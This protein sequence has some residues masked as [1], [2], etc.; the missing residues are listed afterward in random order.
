MELFSKDNMTEVESYITAKAAYLKRPIGGTIELLPLCNMTCKMCY[1]QKS[2]AEMRKEGRMLTCDEWISIAG[3]A[4]EAGVLSILITGGEPLLFPEFERLYK[5]LT[6]MGFIIC[7]NTNGTL[8]NEHWADLFAEYPCRRINMTIY[9]KDNQTYADLCGNPHGFDQ[10][11]NTVALLKERQVP[12]RFN[13]TPS[14]WNF[15]QV[16]EIADIARALDV[17][18]SCGTYIFPNEEERLG[19]ETRPT[20]E[21]YAD[22]YL[23]TA[24]EHHPTYPMEIIAKSRLFSLKK[25][26]KTKANDYHCSA[27]YNGFWIDW[28]GYLST[29]GIYRLSPVNLLEHSFT[30]AWEMAAPKFRD[31]HVCEECENCVKRNLCSV[32]P[33]ANYTETGSSAGKPE[34][35]CKA[36]DAVIKKLL[37]YLQEDERKEYEEFLGWR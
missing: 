30:E 24:H 8:V 36:T 4:K 35:L 27:G 18:L 9:G 6:H 29:C 5:R 20:P 31:L 12:F 32:C 10:L 25:T 19:K 11:M 13:F 7:L 23:Q 16:H 22:L 34:Y 26:A 3:Q 33:A 28:K 1:I 2:H 15:H 14:K 37:S 17:P 21:E